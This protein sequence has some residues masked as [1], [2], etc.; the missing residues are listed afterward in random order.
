MET[1]RDGRSRATDATEAIRAA[2]AALGV[3][4]AAWS[5]VRP[6]VT[7][8]GRPYVDLG[9]LRAEVV[10]QLAEALRSKCH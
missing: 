3:A 5:G 10:E 6:L 7:Q 2:L 9:T 4:E 1:W 8:T